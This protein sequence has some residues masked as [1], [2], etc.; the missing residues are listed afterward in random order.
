MWDAAFGH[1]RQGNAVRQKWLQQTGR[2][3]DAAAN[4]T[5]IDRLIETFDESFFR[6]GRPCGSDSELPIFVVG[7]PRSGSTLLSQILSSH[8]QVVG[9]GELWEITEMVK[10]LDKE[11]SYPACLGTAKRADLRRLANNYLQRLGGLAGRGTIRVIDKMP[12]N[13]LYLGLIALLFPK[14]RIIDCRRDPLDVCLSCYFQNFSGVEF[15]WSLEDLGT[16]HAEYE[17]LMAHWKQ[18]LPLR[19]MEVQYEDLVARQEAVSRELIAFCGLEWQDRCLAF[20]ENRRPVRTASA[21]QVRRPMYASSVG[22]WKHYAAHL[23]PLRQALA[24]ADERGLQA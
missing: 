5:S 7:M 12:Q 17:R 19:I 23:E 3:F 8:S 18:V 24:A 2:A 15:A 10:D 6:N 22:R 20:H 4:R 13:F 21:A 11:S 14:A 16:Y 9:A 1:Y